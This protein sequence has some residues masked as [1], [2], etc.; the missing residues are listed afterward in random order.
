MINKVL[1]ECGCSINLN[2]IK[3]SRQNN[4]YI[5][6]IHDKPIKYILKQCLYCKNEIEFVSVQQILNRDFCTKQCAIAYKMKNKKYLEDNPPLKRIDCVH[7][8]DCLSKAFKKDEYDLGC[9]YC[10]L[11]QFNENF[12]IS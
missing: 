11:Y 12:L 8:A 1:F 4:K 7:Y 3:K 2:N 5:C 6:L 9:G 10:D